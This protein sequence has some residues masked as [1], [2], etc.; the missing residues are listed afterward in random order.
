MKNIFGR[1]KNFFSDITEGISISILD[2]TET[3]KKGIFASAPTLFLNRFSEYDIRKFFSKSGMTSYLASRSFEKLVYKI[4]QDESLVHHL[5]VYSNFEDTVNMLIDLRLSELKFSPENSTKTYDTFLID[6]FMT[7]NPNSLKFKKSK[8]QLPG[9]KSPGL[10][11][12]NIM[13]KIMKLVSCA[14]LNDGF[15]N[16]PDHLHLA[17]MYSRNFYFYDPK[18]EGML[19]AVLRDL[20][21]DGLYN[22]SWA[23][24]TNSIISKSTCKPLQ[25]S[26]SHQV[27]PVSDKMKKHFSS[28]YY[29]KALKL[30]MKEHFYIN[31]EK[32]NKEKK[33]IK[34]KVNA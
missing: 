30:A 31:Y 22:I 19:R 27:Y 34:D 4:F 10:G 18:Y 7:R 15:I 11:L 26:P 2:T 16:V 29:T 25:F 3:L 14:S 17:L 8:P 5:E 9:Q 6:W 24:V 33:K 1:F 12:L 13:I 23:A 28:S 21:N 32:M 20:K